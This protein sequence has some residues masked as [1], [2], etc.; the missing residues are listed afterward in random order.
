MSKPEKVGD[1]MSAYMTYS[2]TTTTSIPSFRSPETT[3]R[4]RF[5]DFLGLHH[6]LNEKYLP[7]GRIVP[8]APEKSVVGK[9]MLPSA[10]RGS[11]VHL[12]C[13]RH[14]QGQILKV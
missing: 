5:S 1:G 7:K 8:P 10:S 3:V 12:P 6:K 2:V 11:T 4:R 13:P 9:N 14:D